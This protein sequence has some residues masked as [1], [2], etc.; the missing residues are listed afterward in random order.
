MI[1]GFSSSHVM[2][3]RCSQ[4]KAQAISNYCYFQ[5]FTSTNPYKKQVVSKLK[6]YAASVLPCHG[7][8]YPGLMFAVIVKKTHRWFR[9]QM[10]DALRSLQPVRA[11]TADRQQQIESV[12]LHKHAEELFSVLAWHGF[13]GRPVPERSTV[14]EPEPIQY[15]DEA[16]DLVLVLPCIQ[17]CKCCRHSSRA[18][19]TINILMVKMLT[20]SA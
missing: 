5:L 14:A 10:W 12:T 11:A 8:Q 1:W 20:D 13:H 17:Q 4:G 18:A 9:F 19:F 15:V 7:L 16:S 3:S 2:G 6:Q